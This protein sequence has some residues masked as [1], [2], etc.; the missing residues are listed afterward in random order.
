MVLRTDSSDE[1]VFAELKQDILIAVIL[2]ILMAIAHELGHWLAFT[3][4]HWELRDYGFYATIRISWMGLETVPN[5]KMS[6]FDP[7]VTLGGLF[8]T[9]P[10]RHLWARVRDFSKSVIFISIAY[11]LV[12]SSLYFLGMPIGALMR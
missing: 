7:L 2:L 5:K 8:G 10:F 1:D 6:I 4:C 12:E 9:L 11:G 3:I